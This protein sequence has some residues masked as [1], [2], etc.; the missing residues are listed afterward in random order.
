MNRWKGKGEGN[1]EKKA[2]LKLINH[3]VIIIVFIDKTVH[4]TNYSILTTTNIN[5]RKKDTQI[6]ASL[7]AETITGKLLFNIF[8]LLYFKLRF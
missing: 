2:K 6:K 1:T 8:I 4:S 3:T 5:L 7:T